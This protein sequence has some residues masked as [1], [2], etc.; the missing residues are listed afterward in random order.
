MKTLL[1]IFA[2]LLV[3]VIIIFFSKNLFNRNFFT[4]S[5]NNPTVMINKQAVSLLVAKTEQEKETGLSGRDSLPDN[6]AMV[7]PFDVA[8]YYGFWMNKMKFPLD[9]VFLRNKHVITVFKNI[10]NPTSPTDKLPIYKPE[11]PADMVIEFPAGRFD[12]LGL[13]TGDTVNISL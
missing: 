6:M 1:G 5:Q 11:Q 13:K 9:I 4:M 7:F 2:I 3:I 12:Q 8:G 10:P